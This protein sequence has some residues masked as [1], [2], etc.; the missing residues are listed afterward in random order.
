MQRDELLKM[1]C[2]DVPERM[3]KHTHGRVIKRKKET[4]KLELKNYNLVSVY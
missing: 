2:K 3:E 1:R 4:L